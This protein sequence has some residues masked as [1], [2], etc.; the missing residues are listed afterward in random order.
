[1]SE[2]NQDVQPQE[3]VQPE[4]VEEQLVE[5]GESAPQPEPVEPLQQGE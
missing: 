2:E 5:G 1:M 3:E 4:N